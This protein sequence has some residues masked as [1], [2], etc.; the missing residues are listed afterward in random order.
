[1]VWELGKPDYKFFHFSLAV[2]LD[3]LLNLSKVRLTPLEYGD[4][5]IYLPGY[6]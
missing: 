1:M 5:N 4:D 3:A 2:I 6:L